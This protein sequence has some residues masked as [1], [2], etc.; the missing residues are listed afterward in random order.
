MGVLTCH[1]GPN[2]TDEGSEDGGTG[3]DYPD[4]DLEAVEMV[5]MDGEEVT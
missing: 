3:C 1:A 5:L 4:V 2:I